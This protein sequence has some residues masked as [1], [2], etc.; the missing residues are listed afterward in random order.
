MAVVYI[1]YSKSINRY[2]IGSTID[3]TE[4][5]KQH[6]DPAFNRSFTIRASDWEL[7]HK[8]EHLNYQL[9]R[10]IEKHIKA[11]KSKQYILNLIKYPEITEKLIQKFN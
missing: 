9:A 5:L 8:I 6:L 3:L 1:L 11:M 2:Y 10:Q 4:R 7:C